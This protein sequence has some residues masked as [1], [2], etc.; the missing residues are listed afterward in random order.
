MKDVLKVTN[1]SISI[2]H[3][4]SSLEL[5]KGVSFSL[6]QGSILG[7]VGESGSGKSLTALAL[8]NLLD[9]NVMSVSGKVDLKAGDLS[10]DLLSTHSGELAKLRGSEIA[11]VFQEP[12]SSI[13]PNKKCGKQLIE[14][15]QIH[16]TKI[17]SKAE[18]EALRLLVD[19][20][21]GEPSRIMNSYPH[22]LSGGQLQR[23]IIAM[24]ICG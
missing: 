11:M 18:A 20:G 19:V 10:V 2:N 13:N 7:V 3:I 22:Q 12:L 6:K 14:I 4:S 9:K 16:R 1:L 23:V 5:V 24:A 21:L 8:M 15:I 17:K